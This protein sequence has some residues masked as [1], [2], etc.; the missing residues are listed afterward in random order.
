MPR[1]KEKAKRNPNPIEKLV[2][3]RKRK[4]KTANKKIKKKIIKW[5]ESY[6]R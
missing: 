5:N 1:N 6:I 3:E 4:S 2:K